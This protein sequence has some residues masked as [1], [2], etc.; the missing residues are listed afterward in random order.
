MNLSGLFAAKPGRESLSGSTQVF[1]NIQGG[2]IFSMTSNG[3]AGRASNSIFGQS[4]NTESTVADSMCSGSIIDSTVKASFV[5]FTRHS[6]FN[7]RRTSIAQNIL[8]SRRRTI[9]VDNR[10]SRETEESLNNRGSALEEGHVND[11]HVAINQGKP[12]HSVVEEESAEF[13]EFKGSVD[14]DS[15]NK[16]IDSHRSG[17]GSGRTHTGINTILTPEQ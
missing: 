15:P 3:V 16:I 12:H 2:S 14:N 5:D 9:E 4:M 11:I 13:E 17:S 1:S 6:S 10:Q 8:N 7:N